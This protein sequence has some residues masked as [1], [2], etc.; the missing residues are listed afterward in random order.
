MTS[1]APPLRLAL[2]GMTCAACA[3]RIERALKR[4][5]G[6][7]NVAV[8]LATEEAFVRGPDQADALIAAV[9]TAGYGATVLAET[10]P[11]RAPSAPPVMPV[12]LACLLTAPLLL[13]MLLAPLGAAIM[14]PVPLALALAA[15][16]QFWL[17]LPFYRAAWAALRTGDGNMDQLVVL[18][19]TAAWALSLY[20][21]ATAPAGTM[22]ALYLESAAAIITF[23]LIGKYLEAR[24]KRHTRDAVTALAALRPTVARVVE[25]NAEVER[26]VA[27]LMPGDRIRVR[28]GERLPADGIIRDGRAGFDES[29]L[30]GESHPVE[31]GPGDP[32]VAG[33]LALDG[34]LEIEVT[35][36]GRGSALGR[37]LAQVEAAESAKAPVQRLVDRVS[38]IFVPTVLVIGLATMLGWWLDGAAPSVAILRGVAVWV[39]ACPCA[40]GLATPAALVAAFG[41]AARH[42]ILLKDPAALEAAHAI[43]LVAFDKTGTLTEGRPVLTEIVTLD[44]DEAASLRLA[45]ALQRGSEHPLGRALTEAFAAWPGAGKQGLPAS[46]HFR[47]LPGVGVAAEIDGIAYAIGT[48]RLLSATPPAA[49][50]EAAQRLE[51]EGRTLSWLIRRE[52]G[53]PLALFGFADRLR[54]GAAGAV[55]RLRAMGVEVAVLTGDSA[56]S[57]AAVA[58]AAHIAD[59][60]SR[61]LPAD[62]TAA[63]AAWQQDGRRVAMVGDGINDAPALAGATLGVAVAD[64]TDVALASAGASIRGGDPQRVA[65]LVA[66]ARA[67]W[68]VIRQN[69]GWAFG[70]NLIGIPLAAVGLLSPTLAAAAMAGSSVAVVTNAL[71]LTRWRPQR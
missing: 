4:V 13:P 33:A 9:T 58:R 37:I 53:T 15:P 25:D 69:L 23:V 24:A 55:A 45:A 38:R 51:A 26:P 43:D 62:K 2:T 16:V 22:P 17:A 49:L 3:G 34:A 50:A 61:L 64:G 27:A 66:L 36:L 44:G 35:A 21:L 6:V 42:G 65:D 67:T 52:D 10:V 12:L 11:G 39:I 5:P 32:V 14:L 30:T 48:S 20:D 68:A 29:V 63:I 54:E 70:F 8:N 19:S 7:E 46:R 56:G 40:L 47:A 31:R 41:S 57:A 18:G 60:R 28:P 1:A 71:R 59:V